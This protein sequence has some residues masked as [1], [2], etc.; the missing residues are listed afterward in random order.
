MA[1]PLG[2]EELC[3]PHL[4]EVSQSVPARL[5]P[6]KI[7]EPSLSMLKMTPRDVHHGIRW[8]GIILPHPRVFGVKLDPCSVR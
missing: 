3:G 7:A 8:R 4:Q 1:A 5:N 6:S 2:E